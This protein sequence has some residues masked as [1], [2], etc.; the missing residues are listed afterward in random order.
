MTKTTPTGH[1]PGLDAM[2]ALAIVFVLAAHSNQSLGPPFGLPDEVFFH[3]GVWGVELFFVLSGYLVGGILIR[4]VRDGFGPASWASFMMRRWRRTIPLYAITVAALAA[5]FGPPLGAWTNLG[6]YALF[7]QWGWWRDPLLS[8]FGVSWSLAIEEW[9]YLLFSV[10]LLGA[11][12]TS[13]IVRILLLILIP[14]ALRLWLYDAAL[15]WDDAYRKVTPLRLDAIGWGVLLAWLHLEWRDCRRWPAVLMGA[16]AAAGIMLYGLA[17]ADM[18]GWFAKTLLFSILP[19]TGCCVLVLLMRLRP[20]EG[21]LQT[22]I[23]RTAMYS[24]CAYLVHPLI[25]HGFEQVMPHGL[26]FVALSWASVLLVC[27][28][29]YRWIEAPLLT[30]R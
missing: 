10:S 21:L 22:V 9:F 23:A 2:R 15:V 19:M 5:V 6:Y 17:F 25:F 18:S 1:V 16:G 27:A 20:G 4:R 24:Y 26:P 28:A 30:R 8:W 12:R 11:T 3:L 29:S 14:L 13:V 7:L